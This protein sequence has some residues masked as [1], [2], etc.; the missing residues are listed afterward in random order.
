[1][2]KII[3]DNLPFGFDIGCR[4]LKLKHTD[5]PFPQLAEFWD[6]IEPITFS[7][8]LSITNTENRRVAFKY[9]G[10]ERLYNEVNPTL[11]NKK[12]LKKKTTWVDKDG[13]LVTHKFKDTYELYKVD[14]SVLSSNIKNNWQKIDDCYF[15][16]CKDTSTDRVYLIWV[17]ISSV[18]RTNN[19]DWFRDGYDKKVNAIQAIAWTIQ[20][21][22]PLGNIEKI[23]RQGDCILFKRKDKTIK[24]LVSPR[25]LTESEYLNLMV[26]E[27]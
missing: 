21:N 1:M 23:I 14:G 8:I 19:S 17:D 11:L 6:D 25:H 20:T 27:S 12:T 13:K 2:K 5:C 9:Y 26:A 3:I 22:I 15:V 7:D 24:P 10:I 18:Y 16:K 4:I